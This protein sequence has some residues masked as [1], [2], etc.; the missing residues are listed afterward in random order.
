[1]INV[2]RII[3]LAV[4]LLLIGIIGMAATFSSYKE[5]AFNEESESIPF[6]ADE[7][8]EIEVDAENTQIRLQPA[9]VEEPIAEYTT[10]GRKSETQELSTSVNG[11]KL[12]IQI[13]ETSFPFF[14]FDFM[15]HSNAALDIFVPDDMME[16]MEVKTTNSKINAADLQIDALQ[17]HTSNGKI[18]G[19][20]IETSFLDIQSSNGKIELQNV[21]G[22]TNLNTSNGKITLEN[23]VGEVTANTNNG[24][25]ELASIQGNTNVETTNGK[26]EAQDISGEMKAKTNNAAIHID[27]ESFDTPMDLQTSNGKITIISEQKPENATF[28]LRTN[29]GRIR[30]F[31]SKDW[32]VTYGDGETLIKAR[33]S[34]GGINIE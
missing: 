15:F 29:N 3:I 16:K 27:T 25:I 7:I 30:V 9:H 34:N 32:D 4:I 24:K 12:T 10:T 26:V 17:L 23:I 20:N 31:D 6:D 8:T 14:D 5:S 19:E 22:D 33:T 2:K 1:M 11:E 18:E 13:K 28:D 21:Q